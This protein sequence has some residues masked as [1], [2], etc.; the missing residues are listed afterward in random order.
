MKNRAIFLEMLALSLLIVSLSTVA[1]TQVAAPNPNILLISPSQI[2]GGQAVGATI[3]FAVKVSQM[4]PFNTWEI[5]VSV[6]PTVL[7]PTAFTITPNTLTAN[8]T[9]SE[10]ELSHCINNGTTTGGTTGCTV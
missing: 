4:D 10:L 7:N 6:D 9:V 5:Y 1:I 3:N 8:Y 2:N